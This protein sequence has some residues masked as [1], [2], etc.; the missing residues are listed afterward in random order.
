MLVVAASFLLIVLVV[1]LLP[2]YV[3]P[4][5]KYERPVVE[6][7]VLGIVRWISYKNGKPPDDVDFSISRDGNN[8]HIIAYP[9]NG[10]FGS[11]KYIELDQYGELIAVLPGK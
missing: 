2:P 7:E 3:P 9:K 6:S 10:P 1:N 5:P 8:W 11:Q 4:P